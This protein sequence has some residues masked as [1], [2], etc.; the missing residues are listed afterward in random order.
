MAK[1]AKSSDPEIW[2]DFNGRMTERGY[3]PTSGTIRDL[4]SLG[5]TLEEAVGRR[6][7]LVSD[8]GDEQGNPDDIM[9]NGTVVRDARSGILL[10][11]DDNGFYHRSELSD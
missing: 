10:E 5:L 9:C 1:R 11:V 3:L 4:T 2:C 6:F 8:D 7:V